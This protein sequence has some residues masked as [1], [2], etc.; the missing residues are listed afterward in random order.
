MTIYLWKTEATRYLWQIHGCFRNCY[1]K[2]SN[3]DIPVE[4]GGNALPLA[5]PGVL[6][7]LLGPDP[8][9]R[10]DRQHLIY[11]IL[12]LKPFDGLCYFSLT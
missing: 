3:D 1:D 7:R 6:Q 5:D 9:G 12:G 8:L 2:D 10:V 11:Q 4:D